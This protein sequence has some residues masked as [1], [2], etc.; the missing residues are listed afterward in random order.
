MDGENACEKLSLHCVSSRECSEQAW[1]VLSFL[2]AKI[3]YYDDLICSD[4]AVAGES[5]L[6]RA[7]LEIN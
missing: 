7:V 5:I 3:F 6:Y 1:P 2:S 4:M